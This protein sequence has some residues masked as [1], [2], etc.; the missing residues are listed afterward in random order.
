MKHKWSEQ[1]RARYK[2]AVDHCLVFWNSLRELEKSMAEDL[3]DNPA[4]TSYEDLDSLV[5][6]YATDVVTADE[7]RDETITK[8]LNDWATYHIKEDDEDEIP[9]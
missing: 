9:Y 7:L 6:D 5:E 2:S 4:E 1:T 8:A 3:G